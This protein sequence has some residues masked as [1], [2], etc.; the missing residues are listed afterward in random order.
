MTLCARSR[1]SEG[2]SSAASS[3]EVTETAQAV[4]Q[5]SGGSVVAIGQVQLRNIRFSFGGK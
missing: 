2:F 1:A 5:L 4:G 3:V